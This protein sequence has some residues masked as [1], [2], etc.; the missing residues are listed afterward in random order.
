MIAKQTTR[1]LALLIGAVFAAPVGAQTASQSP[2]IIF[3]GAAVDL[4]D[5]KWERRPLVVFGDSPNDPRFLQQ[6]DFLTERLT[7]LE[8]RDVI[9]LTDTD[10]DTKSELRRKLR[11][12]GFMIALIGKDGVVFLRKPLP[13]DVRELTR[14]IDKMPLRQREIQERRG[15]S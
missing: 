1:I 4:D 12:R 9:I 2:D 11:P 5:L 15:A 6:M 13:W 8:T 14:A 7:D 10:P 3:D